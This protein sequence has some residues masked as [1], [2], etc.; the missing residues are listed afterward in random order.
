MQSDR[1]EFLAT[2]AA[3]ALA[4]PLITGT[5]VLA[6]GPP[7]SYDSRLMG[8]PKFIDVDGIR[9][10]YFE[11]G[12]GPVLV[13]IHGGQWPATTSAAGFAPIFDRLAASYH[14]YAFD[15]LGMGYTDLPKTL[16]DYS[17]DAITRHAYDF[18]RAAGITHAIVAGHSRGALPAAR[19]AADHPELV[20]HLIIFDTNALAADDITLPERPDPPPPPLAPT[21]EQIRAA[22]IASPLSYNK[23]FITDSYVEGEFRIAQLPKT[24]EAARQFRAAKALWVRDHPEQMRANP[25]LANDQGALVWWMVDAKHATLDLIAAGHL[26]MPTVIIWGWNDPFAPYR[27]GLGAM[28]I[29]SKVNDTVEM[30]FVNHSGH[31]VFAEQPETVTRL[32]NSFVRAYT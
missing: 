17:M 21:R 8:S 1:R 9:T 18:I 13:L 14:V 11:A 5:P 26:K 7:A 25:G 32:I 29:I 20:S 10:R 31:F 27:F 12:R 16:T 24:Q 15:K 4:L 30:H 28:D 19:I 6:A 22:D 23:A 2:A 3:G